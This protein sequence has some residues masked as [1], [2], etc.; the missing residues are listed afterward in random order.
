LR[1]I[2]RAIVNISRVVRPR[3]EGIRGWPLNHEQRKP[4][5]AHQCALVAA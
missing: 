3:P 2:A 1:S 5:A 4:E